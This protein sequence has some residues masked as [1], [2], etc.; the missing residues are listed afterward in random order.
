MGG[1]SSKIHDPLKS[2]KSHLQEEIK[3]KQQKLK[4]LK[5]KEAQIIQNISKLSHSLNS[6]GHHVGKL[7][8]NISSI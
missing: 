5:K 8:Q 4:S 3:T 6:A 1:S 2:T 7:Q